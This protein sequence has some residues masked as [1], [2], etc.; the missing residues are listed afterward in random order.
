MQTKLLCLAVSIIHGVINIAVVFNFIV[1][2]EKKKKKEKK[3]KDKLPTGEI[4]IVFFNFRNTKCL[5]YCPNS[6]SNVF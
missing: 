4:N 6:L 3:D 5:G 1:V 2:N